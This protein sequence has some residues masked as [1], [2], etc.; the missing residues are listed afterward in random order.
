MLDSSHGYDHVSLHLATRFPK[1]LPSTNLL[2]T[3]SSTI[4]IAIIVTLLSLVIAIKMIILV[5]LKI[6]MR[7]LRH[8]L[9]MTQIFIRLVAGFTEPDYGAW[10]KRNSTGM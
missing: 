2:A 3:F 8:N 9:N 1:Q 6:D 10:F 7:L 5:Y 4:W